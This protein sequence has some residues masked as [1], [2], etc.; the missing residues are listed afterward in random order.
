MRGDNHKVAEGIQPPLVE[1]CREACRHADIS[2]FTKTVGKILAEQMPIGQ[3]LVRR[4]D[5]HRPCIDTVAVGFS[6]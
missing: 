2:D 6:A 1:L 5:Q 3:L 4:L